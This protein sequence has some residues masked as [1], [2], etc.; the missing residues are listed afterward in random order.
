MG[1]LLLFYGTFDGAVGA[2][3]AAVA[4]LWRYASGAGFAVVEKHALVFGH[5][6][7]LRFAL[8]CVSFFSCA[9]RYEGAG[10]REHRTS[11]FLEGTM[12]KKKDIDDIRDQARRDAAHQKEM[13]RSRD[14][15]KNIKAVVNPE[16]RPPSNA[17][18]K[19]EYKRI[20]KDEKK[21]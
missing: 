15:L 8:F 20:Y 9:L 13:Q 10:F 17:D 3:D 2:E 5:G 7:R 21:R 16:H 1:L 11:Q 19:K 6:L 14:L 18:Q 4:C 12:G